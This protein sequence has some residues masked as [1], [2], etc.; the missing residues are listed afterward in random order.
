[1]SLLTKLEEGVSVGMLMILA[2]IMGLFVLG[3][4]AVVPQ[5]PLEP[6]V[7]I[8]LVPAPYPQPVPCFTEDQRPILAPETPVDPETATFEQL[9]AAR[10]ADALALLDYRDAIDRLFLQCTAPKG[11][12]S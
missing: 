5:K 10:L 4:C 2:L 6:E 7:R 12:T 8:Q 11:G 1:M 3:G 9:L